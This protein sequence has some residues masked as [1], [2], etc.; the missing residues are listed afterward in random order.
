M[1]SKELNQI[2]RSLE[3]ELTP[4]RYQHTLGV[5]YTAASLA[6][7]Y[8]ILLSDAQLAGLLH[9]CAKCLPL[10]EKLALCNQHQL[11][12]NE[13]ELQNPELLHAK[14]GYVLAQTKYEITNTDVLNAILYHTTG[15]PGM[16]LLEKIIFIADYIE[17]GRNKA[18]NLQQVRKLA[19]VDL[20]KAL[21]QIMADTLAYLEDS[22][23]VI[24]PMTMESYL[25]YSNMEEN[26]N[27]K[28]IS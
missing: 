25:Y 6:M 12:I 1:N 9:D 5:E 3:K 18:P 28:Q 10:E 21:L 16:S 14:A 2:R 15:R 22:D 20:D 7:R 27:G 23:G 11:M 24:D 13:I 4:K 17:P 8:D 19:F 26:K